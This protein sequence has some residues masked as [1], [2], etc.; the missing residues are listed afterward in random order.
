M[1]HMVNKLK[2]SNYVRKIMYRVKTFQ[3]SLTNCE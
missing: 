2:K 1:F 3:F